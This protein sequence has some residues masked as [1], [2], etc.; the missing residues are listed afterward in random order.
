MKQSSIKHNLLV[1]LIGTFTAI[2]IISAIIIFN[3]TQEEANE[4]SNAQLQQTASLVA[5]T[6]ISQLKVESPK[7]NDLKFSILIFDN[8]NRLIKTIGDNYGIN[9]PASHEGYGEMQ[10]GSEK[11]YY[12]CK[13]TDNFTVLSIQPK[14]IRDELSM[15]GSLLSVSSL[16]LFGVVFGL[17]MWFLL[18]RGLK[19]VQDFGLQISKFDLD[20]IEP[21]ATTNLPSELE[22]LAKSI[23]Q[24]AFRLKQNINQQKSFIEDAAH[25]LRTP[26]A[27]LNLQI[28]L[29][30]KSETKE[31]LSTHIKLLSKGITRSNRLVEQLLAMT[32]LEH[33]DNHKGESPKIN[34]AEIL[35]N[36]VMDL[37]IAAEQKEIIMEV[38]KED[39]YID[40]L[41]LDIYTVFRNIIDNAINYSP[42]NSTI[43]I[44]LYSSENKGFFEV[45]DQG[46]GIVDIEKNRVFDRFYRTLNHNTNGSGLGLSIVSEICKKYDFGVELKDNQP[47]GLIVL[48]S[49]VL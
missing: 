18:A 49:F 6:N 27:A 37:Y 34:I 13:Q 5:Y 21:L 32:R 8:Q 41:E 45:I 2:T 4:F 43:I 39:V 15:I 47:S 29:V 16:L 23:N 9:T 28:D 10:M 26:L 33:I 35:S 42:V 14:S 11:I 44:K 20:N 36:V 24:M 38:S 3:T 30:K 40:A 7:D 31:E 12:Y 25:E 17:L 1:A 19:P 48:V 22:P 46:A